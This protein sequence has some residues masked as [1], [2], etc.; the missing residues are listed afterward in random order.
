MGRSRL[1]GR[2]NRAINATYFRQWNIF[3][4]S[5][6]NTVKL[7]HMI[8]EF[9]MLAQPLNDH[10]FKRAIGVGLHNLAY[11][12]EHSNYTVINSCKGSSQ[13]TILSSTTEYWVISIWI[14]MMEEEVSNWETPNT[15][16][17]RNLHIGVMYFSARMQCGH[18]ILAQQHMA[19]IMRF[20]PMTRTELPEV[21]K[22]AV[23]WKFLNPGDTTERQHCRCRKTHR[24]N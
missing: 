14:H 8:S 19:S 18:V 22:I 13:Y 17:A 1:K 20:N 23:T 12:Y 7:Q 2:T 24:K 4:L 21:H 6:M 11:L 3:N 5:M 15:T 9:W 16:E 10:R